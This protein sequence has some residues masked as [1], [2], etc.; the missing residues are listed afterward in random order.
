MFVFVFVCVGGTDAIMRPE[1]GVFSESFITIVQPIARA[2]PSF[3]ACSHIRLH[4]CA[5]FSMQ[6]TLMVRQTPYFGA[7][8][9]STHNQRT[10]RWDRDSSGY[11]HKEREI[12]WDDGAADADRF[13]DRVGEGR[14]RV[15]GQ[16]QQDGRGCKRGGGI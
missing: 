8:Q 4:S 11:L 6:H 3:Q 10:C 9:C 12:P 15:P 7:L 16:H 14:G 5:Q 2:G 1:S 13:M